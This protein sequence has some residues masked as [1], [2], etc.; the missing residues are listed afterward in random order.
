GVHEGGWRPEAWFWRD[1]A[2]GVAKRG[3]RERL[4]ELWDLLVLRARDRD[5]G[6]DV[7][8]RSGKGKAGGAWK[9]WIPF[10]KT[11][12][13]TAAAKRDDSVLSKRLAAIFLRAL[14]KTKP[15]LALEL[16]NAAPEASNF[17][18]DQVLARRVRGLRGKV[19]N[20]HLEAR[21]FAK[22]SLVGRGDGVG[23]VGKQTVGVN[24]GKSP[25]A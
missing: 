5:G 25:K 19:D 16:W 3:S 8:G 20:G 15:A 12:P 24:R 13:N 21:I 18:T 22:R 10:R 14:S 17:A 4:M 11:Q 9:I 6:G 1:V 2:R 23:K 7:V